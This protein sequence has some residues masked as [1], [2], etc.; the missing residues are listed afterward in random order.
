MKLGSPIWRLRLIAFRKPW[1]SRNLLQRRLRQQL[2]RG[3]KS[4]EGRSRRKY[5]I[6]YSSQVDFSNNIT[7]TTEVDQLKSKVKQYADYDE[8]KRELEIMKV[9]D[10][11]GGA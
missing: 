1:K 7:Q 9:R 10:M 11:P 2:P 8:I 4:L 5:E 3:L 6:Y